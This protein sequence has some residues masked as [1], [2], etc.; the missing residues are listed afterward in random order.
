MLVKNYIFAL[1]ATA[2]FHKTL[3]IYFCADFY[4]DSNHDGY[5]ITIIIT[6][7][8]YFQFLLF[9]IF[10]YFYELI[11]FKQQNNIFSFLI[12]IIILTG[13]Y[14][15]FFCLWPLVCFT[16]IRQCRQS[17]IDEITFDHNKRRMDH[18]II[19]YAYYETM[20]TCSV[21]A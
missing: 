16:R 9:N 4:F 13:R 6:F 5:C 10:Y 11:I 17:T 2:F 3:K 7:L 20:Y 15:F 12:I 19:L 18:N 14:N 1:N 21:H 8:W